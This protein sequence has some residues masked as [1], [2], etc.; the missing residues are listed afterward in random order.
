MVTVGRQQTVE[1]TASFAGGTVAV[2]STPAGAEVWGHA[3]QVVAPQR[4]QVIDLQRDG[5]TGA[6]TVSEFL[7]K[8]QLPRGAVVIVDEAGRLARSRCSSF[9][10]T[11]KTMAAGSSCPATPVSTG[12]GSVRRVVGHQ[13]YSGLKPAELKEIRRQ[14]PARGK[15]KAERARIAEYKQAV[16]EACEIWVNSSRRLDHQG[17]IVECWSAGKIGLRRN[18]LSSFGL[19]DHAATPPELN[20][21]NPVEINIS[22]SIE[23]VTLRTTKATDITVGGDCSMPVSWA[24]IFIPATSRPSMSPARS[25]FLLF[26][27][28]PNCRKASRAL[29]RLSRP[30]GMAFSLS[31]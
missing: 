13:K 16:K 8:R 30:P 23:N 7:T 10:T 1:A 26:T 12:R 15:T 5:M 19:N 31:W 20:N 17:A 24:R 22:G 21:P 2:S 25:L 3:L 14:D 28:S 29:I 6:Q 11:C 9:F 4:Q 18:S 27:R